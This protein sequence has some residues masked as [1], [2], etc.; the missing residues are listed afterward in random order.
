MSQNR[1]PNA[2]QIESEDTIDIKELWRVVKSSQRAILI[3][4]GVVVIASV[5]VALTTRPVYQATSV[6]MIK[7]GKSNARSFVFDMGGG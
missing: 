6:V 4:F 3:I 5:I 1:R 7:E 2:H